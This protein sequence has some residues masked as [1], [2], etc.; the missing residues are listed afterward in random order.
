MYYSSYF[1]YLRFFFAVLPKSKQATHVFRGRLNTKFFLDLMLFFWTF[2]EPKQQ[3]LM[4]NSVGI[5]ITMA[6]VSAHLG[7][8]L[9]LLLF[10][11][12]IQYTEY[13]DSFNNFGLLELNLLFSNTSDSSP[14]LE[15]QV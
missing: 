14:V 8:I 10:L 13:T 11:L 5:P 12:Y 15:N 1:L 6:L 3:W 9:F 7:L 4:L 2:L